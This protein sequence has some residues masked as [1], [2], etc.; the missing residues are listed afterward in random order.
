MTVFCPLAGTHTLAPRISL[1]FLLTLATLSWCPPE[2][3]LALYLTHVD[4]VS[5]DDYFA[6]QKVEV[7]LRDLK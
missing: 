4:P 5:R 6:V 2:P 7:S 3:P 1:P